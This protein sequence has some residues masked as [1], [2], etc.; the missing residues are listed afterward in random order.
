M[1]FVEACVTTAAGSAM[2]AVRQTH[3]KPRGRQL[4][5]TLAGKKNIL[6]TTH[7]HPDPDA[8]AAALAM[9]TLLKAKLESAKVTVSVK[10]AYGGGLNAA[11]VQ[12]TDLRPTG[13]EPDKLASYDAIVLLDT[14]PTFGNSPLPAGLLPTV[15]VDHHRSK[16]GRRPK[17][18]FRDIRPD[19]GAS[20]TIIFSYF[21]ELEVP[22]PRD[23]AAVLLF[24]IETDL[25]G[26]ASQPDELDNLALSSLTLLADTRKLY[27]MRYIDIPQSYFVGFSQVLASAMYYDN[28]LIAHLQSSDSP[29][30]PAVMADMLLR[31]DQVIYAL[32]TAEVPGALTLSL[33]TYHQGMSAAD[34]MRRLLKG[35]GDGGG[36]LTKAGG[37]IHLQSVTPAE[38][39]RLLATL[40]RRFLRALGIKNTR[41]ARLVP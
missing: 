30:K 9:Q 22:I 7:E 39:E 32:V 17:C 3:G 11:F 8:L 10:G 28:A 40:R 12:Y 38:I 34:L 35:L 36:H 5:R 29:E 2:K 21:M 23:L 31:F 14:Q 25:A 27:K 18:D 19:V 41:G 1:S 37:A 4:L 20:S 6:V 26:A 24:A 13:W 33:R 15:V 16:R